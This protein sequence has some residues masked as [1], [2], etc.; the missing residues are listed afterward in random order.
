MSGRLHH[1]LVITTATKLFRVCVRLYP[2]RFRVEYGAEMEALFQR[3][4]I[5]AGSAG[6]APLLWALLIAL[7]D[8]VAGAVAERFPARRTARGH[9]MFSA[10]SVQ[11]FR[12][13]DGLA[14]DLKLGGRMLVR[15]PGL[16]VIA[17]LAMAFGICVGTVIFQMLS[18]FLYPSLPLPQGDRL[19]QIRNWNVAAKS[20]EPR[21]L[22]DFAVWRSSLRSVT[23]LGAWRDVARNLMVTEGDARPVQVAEI[24]PSAFRVADATPLMGRVLMEADERPDA[25][26]VAVIGHDVWVTRFGSDPAVLGK[27]VRLGTEHVTVVGVMREGFA[28][29]IAHDVWTP[30]RIV[31]DVH[32]PR[33]GPAI[34]VF[35]LLAPG[36]TLETAQA[37]L[38][39]VG[40]RLASEQ[41]ATH[42]QL[43]PRVAHYA[44]L[45]GPSQDD[46]GIVASIYLFSVML[47]VLICSN[48]ALL[49]FARAATRESELAVRTALG[50]S[51]S[52]IVAQLFA[53]ALVLGGVAAVI[54]LAAAHLALNNWGLPFLKMNLGRLPFWYDVS[55][56]PATVLFALGLTVLGSAIAGVMPALKVTRR[57]GSRL[58]QATAGA[59]GMQFG[60]IWTAVIVVQ[61][62]ITVAF[63]AV[64]YVEQGQLRHIQTFDAGFAAE[65]YLA[66]HLAMETPAAAGTIGDSDRAAQRGAFASSVEELRRRVAAEP[67]VV[68][69]TFADWLPRVPDRPWERIELPDAAPVTPRSESGKTGA[70]RR[71]RRWAN[72]ARVEPSYFDVLNAPMLAGRSFAA[73]DLAP[74]A[75]VAIV[76]QGFVDLV[77]Q[78]RNPI[79][80]QVRFGHDP[81]DTA[82]KPPN[83]WIEIV[84]V[85][86]ELGMGSPLARERAAGL[87]LPATPDRFDRVFIMV[88]G[89]GDPMTLAPQV[90][91]IA[92]AVDPTLRLGEWQP[93]GRVLDEFLWFVKLWMRVTVLMTAVALLLSLSGIYA[94]L[95]FIVARRTREIGVRVALGASRRRVIAAIFRRPLIQVGLGVVAGGALIALAATVETEMPGLAGDLSFAQFAIVV[96]YAIFM[97]GVCLLAC[98]VP[99]RR[100]LSV[101]PTVA[102]RLE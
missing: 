100:A 76:D 101:E 62:A 36:A 98:I 32:A 84:G 35:G 45:D 10:P 7:Q 22:H 52:R 57:M 48:V 29:P 5:R 86:K 30:L 80:Q 6:T 78:G 74:G 68:A 2:R 92:A 83:P 97:L 44:M 4:M 16:T 39:A 65:E 93:L 23:D 91:A 21:A 99:T 14:L 75:S 28:F 67:G 43:Q 55:L 61:V 40:Q 3:R 26:S 1:D 9:S 96:A 54:G 87:Y 46:I 82:A 37:E 47:L 95:S 12:I 53:E 24:T 66:V 19:V 31:N 49:L 59:G 34:S 73:A 38:T 64:V 77:L 42:A 89:R 8:V 41:P 18:I 25:P 63:P 69:V 27:T 33:S 58:K 15:Y 17:G 79:G 51:R 60:G 20:A 13:F 81:D 56:S 71:P 90:R 70:V 85:V 50:A 88:H 11:G 102:L 94:V 72:V